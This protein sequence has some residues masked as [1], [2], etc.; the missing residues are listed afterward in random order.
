M[1]KTMLAVVALLFTVA[2]ASAQNMQPTCKQCP[3]TYIP[4]QEL[5][6]YVEKAITDHLLDQQVR[7][8]DAGKTNI[9]IGMIYRGKLDG[10]APNSVAEHDQVSEVYHIIEGTATIVTGPDLVGAKRRAPTDQAVRQLNGPGN[11]AAAIKDGVSHNLKAGD[12]LIIPAGTGHLFTK[13]DD[14]IV[15]LMVRVDPDK[16]TPPKDEA[17][18]KAYLAGDP[19][20]SR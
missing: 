8:V 20:K 19:N 11:N 1:V 13:I 10:P 9:A 7:S 6:A 3:S 15:Y 18:S 16:V 2:A 17:A 5:H 4:N 14:H 12:V